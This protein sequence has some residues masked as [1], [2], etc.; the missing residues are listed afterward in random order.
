MFKSTLSALKLNVPTVF[1]RSMYV[2]RKA[3][4]LT[5]TEPK[6]EEKVIDL[7]YDTVNNPDYVYLL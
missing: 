5:W 7:L 2:K 4:P 3:I 1:R 6:I